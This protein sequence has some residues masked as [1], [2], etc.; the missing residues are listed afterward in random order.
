MALWLRIDTAGYA[1]QSEPVPGNHLRGPPRTNTHAWESEAGWK[2]SHQ[3]PLTRLPKRERDGVI[4]NVCD[5]I[6]GAVSSL[7]QI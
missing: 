5:F 3:S 2:K 7:A 6:S 4:F 1:T